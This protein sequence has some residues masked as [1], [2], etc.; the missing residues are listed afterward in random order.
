MMVMNTEKFRIPGQIGES[1]ATVIDNGANWGI[2]IWKKAN[3]KPFTDGKGSV[4]N[5]PSHRGDLLQIQ[6]LER[7]AKELGQ[8]DGSYEF[9]PGMGRVSE[10]EYSEQVDRMKQGLIPNLNDLGAV[11]AAK[12]TLELYGDDE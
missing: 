10:E 8:E 3:G 4:L 6:K 1:K 5:V 11:M 7:A 12:K 2:Y 9:Y